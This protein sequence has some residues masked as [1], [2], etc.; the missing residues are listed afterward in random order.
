MNL[1]ILDFRDQCSYCKSRVIWKYILCAKKLFL[2][3]IHPSLD[4]NCPYMFIPIRETENCNY[5]HSLCLLVVHHAD[6][7]GS[8]EEKHSH[9]TGG[10]YG[11]RDPYCSCR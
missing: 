2:S 8:S 4:P 1:L 6:K 3:V 9:H 10:N 11:Y 7:M 5:S